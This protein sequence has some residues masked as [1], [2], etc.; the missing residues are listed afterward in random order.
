LKF[1]KGTK[2]AG[3]GLARGECS[4]VDRAMNADE[5]HTLSQSVADGWE[6]L[7]A[8]GTLPAENRW[9]EELHSPDKY[10]TFMVYATGRQFIVTNARPKG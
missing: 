1:T 10:W 9:Y 2:P 8:E 7:K 5:S 6:R 3:G 4:W